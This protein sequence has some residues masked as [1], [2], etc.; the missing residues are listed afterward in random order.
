MLDVGQYPLSPAGVPGDLSQWL[1]LAA[2][3]RPEDP[4]DVVLLGIGGND[5]GFADIG[6]LAVVATP[7]EAHLVLGFGQDS[8]IDAVS[9][10]TLSCP[11]GCMRVRVS[12]DEEIYLKHRDGLMRYASALVGPDGGADIVSTVVTK[13]LGSGKTLMDLREPRV[14]LMRAVLNESLRY[15]D[16]QWRN[17]PT[18]FDVEPI[19]SRPEVIEAVVALPPKQRAAIYLVYWADLPS[20]EAATLMGCRPA[21][22]R[23]YLHL[24]RRKLKEALNDD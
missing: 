14:Y 21:T 22:V 6:T 24:A 13:L 19:E 10:A 8:R 9:R 20:H 23:R 5:V 18:G 1:A 15:R 17:P 11:C 4:L 16:K 2:F 12:T 7:I 3:D